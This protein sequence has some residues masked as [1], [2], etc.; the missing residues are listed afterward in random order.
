[1]EYVF[2]SMWLLVLTILLWLVWSL[3]FRSVVPVVEAQRSESLSA[4]SCVG[5]LHCALSL[6]LTRCLL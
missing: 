2:L 5:F 3:C 6:V 4:P 1:M